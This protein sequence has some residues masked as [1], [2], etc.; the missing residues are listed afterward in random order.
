MQLNHNPRSTIHH[1]RLP[2]R[3]FT[4]IELLVV[5][6]II[7]IL[8]ALLMPAVQQAREV[9]RR[10]QCKHNLMQLSLALFN[11]QMAFE[12][13]PA[14]V[15]NPDG[16][17]KTQEQGHHV[18]WIVSVLPYF[19][20]QNVYK[21]LDLSLSVYDPKNSTPRNH[22]ITRLICPT[23]VR[24]PNLAQPAT[25]YAG[26]HHDVEMAIDEDQHGLL[27]RNSAV[28]GD[29][30]PDGLS[31]TLLLGEKLIEADDLGWTSGTRATL[32]NAGEPINAARRAET[33]RKAAQRAK[34]A[35]KKTAADFEGA[36]GPPIAPPD[37]VGQPIDKP[38]E[39]ASL[40][41][42]KDPLFVGGFASH[43]AGGAHFSLADSSVRFFSEHMDL[44]LLQRL[45]H[46]SDGE[47][48]NE[49]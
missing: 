28:R 14:G 21:K 6:A 17:I 10:A 11:Y 16:P 33:A 45:A 12:V 3:G 25:S 39:E 7:A 32:R 5:I 42:P 48:V 9:A 20:E 4:L 30:V 43:H 8:I 40:T 1:P 34:E 29:D 47:L 19:D 18:S 46:R 15:L 36:S 2:R 26:C 44:K 41:K 38:A 22:S 37:A 13:F 23:A 31:H 49:F 24:V 35:P 27:F